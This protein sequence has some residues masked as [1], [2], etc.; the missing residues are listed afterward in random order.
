[1]PLVKV[2][3]HRAFADLLIKDRD[4]VGACSNGC[5]VFVFNVRNKPIQRLG[6][7]ECVDGE[8]E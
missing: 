6:H 2:D 8:V 4:D 5:D 1:M 3:G 7:N